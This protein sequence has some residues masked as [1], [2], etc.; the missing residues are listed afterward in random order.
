[1]ERAGLGFSGAI[2]GGLAL[3]HV[4]GNSHH[5]NIKLEDLVMDRLNSLP[6]QP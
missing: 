2:A 3:D 1:M 4:A 5:P 6:Q